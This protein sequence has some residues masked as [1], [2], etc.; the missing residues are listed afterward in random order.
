MNK[1]GF[2]AVLVFVLAFIMLFSCRKEPVYKNQPPVAVAGNDTIVLLPLDSFVLNGSASY[3]PDGNIGS[4]QW[5][6]ISGPSS[7]KIVNPIRPLLLLRTLQPVF[8][9]LNYRY[10]ILWD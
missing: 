3:D 7:Y 10:P 4:F 9:D 1:K 8:M 5:S 6:K 2:L